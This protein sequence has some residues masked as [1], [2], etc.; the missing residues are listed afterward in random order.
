MVHLALHLYCGSTENLRAIHDPF[1]HWFRRG[2]QRPAS[3][4]R[5]EGAGFYKRYNHSNVAKILIVDDDAD[6]VTIISQALRD[7]GHEVH[8][9]EEAVAGMEKARKLKP[10]VI[11]LDYHMPGTTGA[12]LFESFRRNSTTADIPILFMSGEATNEQ[13]QAEIADDRRSKFLPKPAH[14]QDIRNAIDEL[15]H[16][17]P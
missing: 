2:M 4:G 11:L 16:P 14:I 12:H 13:I 15:L 17:T 8:W 10:D 9:A 1:P 7:Y 3:R 6:L 5:Q